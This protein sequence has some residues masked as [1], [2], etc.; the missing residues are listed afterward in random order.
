MNL[1]DMCKHKM[2]TDPA[3]R[4]MVNRVKAKHK[5]VRRITAFLVLERG[6][7]KDKAMEYAAEVA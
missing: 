1:M 3:Y 5:E 6:W 2:D 7:P 4:R